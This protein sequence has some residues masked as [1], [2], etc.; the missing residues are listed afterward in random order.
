MATIFGISAQA[1]G[2][3]AGLLESFGIEG[4]FFIAHLIAFILVVILLRVFAFKP[5]QQILEER[6]KRI[7]EGEQMRAES[8]K[9]LA[10]AKETGE[11]IKEEAREEGR[12]S[13]AR[14]KEKADKLLSD[15]E[16]EAGEIARHIVEK[17]REAAQQEALRS[18][19]DLKVE[20]SRLVAL[21]TEQVTGKIL[22]EEDHRRIND[23]AISQL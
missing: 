22:T 17:T 18:Q 15:K 16:E 8:E 19:E 4:E 2:G 3:I 6:K 23:E 12:R 13:I 10:G 14:A 5:I 1:S 20:F 9:A 21:A 7:A 11:I